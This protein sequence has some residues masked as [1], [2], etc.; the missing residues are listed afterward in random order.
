MSSASNK[1]LHVLSALYASI[2]GM[3]IAGG[4]NYTFHPHLAM[5]FWFAVFW[6]LSQNL[7]KHFLSSHPGKFYLATCLGRFAVLAI[8]EVILIAYKDNE[9]NRIFS[10]FSLLLIFLIL[11]GMYYL[12]N[13][14][15]A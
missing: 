10:E 11:I 3:M 4:L 7:V 2:C 13:K 9:M 1:G 8:F 12:P 14:M 6:A 15:H 5:I